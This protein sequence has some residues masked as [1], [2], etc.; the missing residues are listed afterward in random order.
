LILERLYL[1]LLKKAI[2]K[3]KKSRTKHKISSIAGKHSLNSCRRSRRKR[4][5]KL[6][7]KEDNRRR[8]K[9][10]KTLSL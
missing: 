3:T 8:N 4:I 1:V 9:P 5:R 2:S 7:K 10:K 6:S